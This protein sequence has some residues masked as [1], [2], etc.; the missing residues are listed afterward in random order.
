MTNVH[1]V[2]LTDE[3]RIILRSALCTESLISA[4][5]NQAALGNLT[6]TT[7]QRAT[8]AITAMAGATH[9]LMREH[10]A[11]LQALFV[12]LA[13]TAGEVDCALDL[14]HSEQ[15]LHGA[16]P[17]DGDNDGFPCRA[18]AKDR[19][20]SPTIRDRSWRRPGPAR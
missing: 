9:D 12:K 2:D 13:A 3:E 17:E 16:H 4:Y 20:T 1:R 11:A 6:A 10:P 14:I 8:V 5:T 18:V 15:A 19:G 7:Q